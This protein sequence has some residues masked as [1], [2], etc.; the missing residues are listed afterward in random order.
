[1]KQNCVDLEYKK[2]PAQMLEVAGDLRR[3]PAKFENPGLRIYRVF[4]RTV[5]LTILTRKQLL[6]LHISSYI[7]SSNHG[8]LKGYRDKNLNRATVAG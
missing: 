6:Q 2:Y 1:M 4:R 7:E 8:S 3:A 5:G